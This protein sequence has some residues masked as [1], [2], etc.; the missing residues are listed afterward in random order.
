MR[1]SDWSSDVCSSDLQ[2]IPLIL[3][4]G[5]SSCYLAVLVL[6]LYINSPDVGLLYASPKILWLLCPMLLLW[7]C[8]VWIMTSRG[9]MND[10]PEIG[11]ATCRERVCQSE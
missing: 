9:A 10:D 7:I 8:R 2:D 5:V 3:T 11:R 6:A 4:M 1:I